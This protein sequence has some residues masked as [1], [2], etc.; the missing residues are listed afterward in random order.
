MHVLSLRS[1]YLGSNNAGQNA[2]CRLAPEILFYSIHHTSYALTIIDNYSCLLCM[3]NIVL[4][5]YRYCPCI[6]LALSQN[7][8]KLGILMT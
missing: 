5:L 7:L 6:L 4:V 2:T 1:S 3:N 8:L